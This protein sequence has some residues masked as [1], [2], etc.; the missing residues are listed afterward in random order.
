[1]TISARIGMRA[2]ILSMNLFNAYVDSL[3][4]RRV[5]AAYGVTLATAELT[6][7]V[8]HQNPR[9]HPLTEQANNFS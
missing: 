1:M 3:H 5:L 2:A 8:V 6:R 7:L 4:D 9:C